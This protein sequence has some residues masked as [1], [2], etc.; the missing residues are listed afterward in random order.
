MTRTGQTFARAG[1][2]PPYPM[3][4]RRSRILTIAFANE[5]LVN[6][7]WRS[8]FVDDALTCVSVRRNG[9][10]PEASNCPAVHAQHLRRSCAT[11][12]TVAHCTAAPAEGSSIFRQRVHCRHSRCVEHAQPHDLRCPVA[13]RRRSLR[14]VLSRDAPRTAGNRPTIGRMF[15]NTAARK[16]SGE[17]VVKHR[18][19][20]ILG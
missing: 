9:G 20:P 4:S 8:R 7:R 18:S 17:R 1:S 6:R 19:E 10:A 3:T 13:Q 16:H 2:S 14:M 11:A 12:R 5:S 15:P